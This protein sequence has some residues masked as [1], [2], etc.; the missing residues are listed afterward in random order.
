MEN[1]LAR[2]RQ[3]NEKLSEENIQLTEENELYGQE[4]IFLR[5]QLLA[6]QTSE[7]A[8]RKS[9]EVEE[10]KF[11]QLR[12]AFDACKDDLESTQVLL[13]QSTKDNEEMQGLVGQLGKLREVNSSLSSQLEDATKELRVCLL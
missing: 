4:T 5:D 8:L 9:S 11:Q 13:Q 6:T 3:E 1:E 7:A 10:E 2:G 12:Q